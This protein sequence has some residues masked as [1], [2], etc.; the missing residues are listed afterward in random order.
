MIVASIVIDPEF[1]SI[2][3]SQ[4][5]DLA[6]FTVI[7]AAAQWRV[8]LDETAGV[9]PSARLI[10]TQTNSGLNISIRGTNVGINF[11]IP[12]ARILI[13]AV[14]NAT[15]ALNPIPGSLQFVYVS[16]LRM[17]RDPQAA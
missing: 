5:F 8:D 3:Q 7:L 9:S 10:V 14:N 6:T 17:F 1:D 12:D 13:Q 16:V 11:G 15:G 4:G 2:V